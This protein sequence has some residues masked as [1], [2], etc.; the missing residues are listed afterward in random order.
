MISLLLAFSFLGFPSLH[1]PPHSELR[2]MVFLAYSPALPAEELQERLPPS[3][4][5]LFRLPQFAKSYI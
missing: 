5:L 4:A 1:T 2:V 3:P